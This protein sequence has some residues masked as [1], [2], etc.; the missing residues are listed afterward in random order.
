MFPSISR[1]KSPSITIERSGSADAFA[2]CDGGTVPS[3]GGTGASAA[4]RDGRV[5]DGARAGISPG[6]DKYAL[7]SVICASVNDDTVARS[8]T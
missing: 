2:C 6:E 3:F 1:R 7:S 5:I 8:C 4:P